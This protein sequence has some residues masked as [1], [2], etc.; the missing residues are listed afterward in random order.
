M[1]LKTT[2]QAPFTEES[3]ELTPDKNLRSLQKEKRISI[4]EKIKEME[5]FHILMHSYHS[6]CSSLS[7]KI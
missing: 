1:L 4:L 3:A 5:S 2:A 7:R 6:T